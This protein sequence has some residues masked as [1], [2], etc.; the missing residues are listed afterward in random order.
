MTSIQAISEDDTGCENGDT[1]G[2][3]KGTVPKESA[4]S[5]DAATDTA[6]GSDTDRTAIS[7]SKVDSQPR[8]RAL[9]PQSNRRRKSLSHS[10]ESLVSLCSLEEEEK[11]DELDDEKDESD[12]TVPDPDALNDSTHLWVFG[13]GSILWKT[14]FRYSRRKFGYVKGYVRRFWQGN[15]THRGSHEAVS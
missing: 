13:Y 15:T 2:D 5:I 12:C 10:S 3:S 9:R 14:G 4:A 7:S 1:N 6:T 11:E 8:Q